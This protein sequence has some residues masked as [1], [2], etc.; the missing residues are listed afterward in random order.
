MVHQ[1]TC[2]VRNKDTISQSLPKPGGMT[3]ECDLIIR[4]MN[5]TS[6]KTC[7][8]LM[9]WPKN[10]HSLK[11]NEWMNEWMM[12]PSGHYSRHR[13]FILIWRT[14]V[15]YL[16]NKDTMSQTL[17]QPGNQIYDQNCTPGISRVTKRESVKGELHVYL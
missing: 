15:I 11:E 9:E 14:T 13:D 16:C 3:Q 5:G 4:L 2:T 7:L 12:T 1:P 8:N 10:V 17:T 6:T